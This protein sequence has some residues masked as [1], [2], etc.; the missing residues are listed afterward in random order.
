MAPATPNAQRHPTSSPSKAPAGTP[1]TVPIDTPDRINALARA[2]RGPGFSRGPSE[3]PTVQK[4]PAAMPIRSLPKRMAGKELNGDENIRQRQRSQQATEQPAPIQP[5]PEYAIVIGAASAPITL[6]SVTIRPTRPSLSPRSR[7]ICG[8]RPTGRN[9][10]LT[11]ANDAMASDATAAHDP[12]AGSSGSGRAVSGRMD[13]AM[14]T[15]GFV[16]GVWASARSWRG[17]AH[18]FQARRAVIDSCECAPSGRVGISG[19]CGKPG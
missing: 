2:D 14:V 5:A 16:S 19:L 8:S 4:P 1:A 9:S 12:P 7:T 17:R 13:A 3:P 15:G 11:S 18:T 10:L 6:G